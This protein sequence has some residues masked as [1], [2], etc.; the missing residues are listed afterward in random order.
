MS[1]QLR[2]RKLKGAN[3]KSLFTFYLDIYANGQ[4]RTETIKHLIFD[5]GASKEERNEVQKQAEYV[6]RIKSNELFNI[7]HGMPSR[8]KQ[9]ID[10]I[11]YYK[12]L[13][14]EKEEKKTR[15]S[16]NNT[17]NYLQEY[18]KGSISFNNINEE[19]IS[20]FIKYL[21][22]F[23]LSNNSILTYLHK[24]KAAL[25]QAVKEK[26]IFSNPAYN[27]NSLKKIETEKVHLTIK[28]LG[29][30]ARTKFYHDGVKRAF[31]F[32][33]YTGIRISDIMNLK[34]ENVKQEKVKRVF[35][36]GINILQKKTKGYNYLPI[37]SIA[38]DL[39]GKRKNDN[40][41]VFKLHKH[42]R[43]I[44]KVLD[45]LMDAAKINKNIS[46]HCSRH[47]NAVL[48]LESGADIYTVSKLLGHKDLKST[49]VYAKVVDQTKINAVNKLPKIK[50]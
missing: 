3:K 10:F 37:N 49:Q 1:V 15:E 30:I 46:F 14:K 36:Y 19:W 23:K 48:L 50:L 12:R 35:L 32:A 42:A 13:M 33:C 25:N 18:A 9:K 29:I 22:K 7:E 39:M 5:E 41:L 17:L 2:K 16:W 40:E 44:N 26:I 27:V 31:L 38:I 4:R 20:G 8:D 21:Q 6:A 43:S 11:E 47:T 24:V 45:K 28:E 34:W